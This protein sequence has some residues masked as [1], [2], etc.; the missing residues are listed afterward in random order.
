[1]S[2]KRPKLAAPPGAC[3]THMH[4]Y[5][6]QVP[7]APGTF[8]PG[9]FPVEAYAAMQ[10]RVGLERVVVVQ[11]NA[12][13]DDNR[14]TL[15]AIARIGKGAKGV[16]VVKFGVTDA[17]LERLTKAGICALR[18]MTLHGG[19]LGFEVMDAMMARVH[20]FGWHANIQLDGRELPKHEERI[21]RLPGKFVIDH[22]GKFLEP[23]AVDS[24]PFKALLRLVDTGRCWVK[25]SAPY[26]TSKSGRPKYEDV[27]RLAKALVKHAPERMLWASNWPHP[28]ERKDPPDDADLLDLLLEWAEDDATRRKILSDNPAELYAFK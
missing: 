26:E 1:M 9:H 3:D 16:G 8:M 24:E 28:S 18:I 22:T 23:V 7:G 11:P 15:D 12:Y 6:A 2:E 5:D 4:F 10:K 25:L 14:V 21:K 20:P 27:G 19:A 17:E 13:A